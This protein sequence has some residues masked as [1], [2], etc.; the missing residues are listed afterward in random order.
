MG[1]LRHT[2]LTSTSSINSSATFGLQGVNRL[3]VGVTTAYRGAVRTVNDFQVNANSGT[4]HLDVG[5]AGGTAVFMSV[6]SWK[7]TE[8]PTSGTASYSVIV[9]WSG[10]ISG[11]RVDFFEFDNID[12]TAGLQ[13]I[14]NTTATAVTAGGSV[15]VTLLNA[16]GDIGVGIMGAADGTISANAS[17]VFAQA[18]TTITKWEHLTLGAQD[19]MGI[20]AY[21][22]SVLDD[23]ETYSFTIDTGIAAA[24]VDS[25]IVI[26]FSLTP[27]SGAVGRSGTGS[28]VATTALLSGIGTRGFNVSA[29]FTA[30]AATLSGT[31]KRGSVGSAIALLAGN[32]TMAGSGVAGKVGS[33]VLTANAAVIA[34]SGIRTVKN[35]TAALL[36]GN[37]TINGTGIREIVGSG[38]MNATTAIL[39]GT[40][41]VVGFVTGSGGLSSD[42]AVIA[43]SGARI[44]DFT[45]AL[46]A[47][48]ATLTGT[49]IRQVNSIT[50]A[51]S[52]GAATIS[53]NNAGFPVWRARDAVSASGAPYWRAQLK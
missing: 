46:Q 12:Q 15:S 17:T 42:A 32:A 41:S 34:G 10:V 52:A 29:S 50:A 27:S 18:D 14:S 7:D 33:G 35:A 19:I 53:G 49:G 3:L 28:L 36:A 38:A 45:A 11:A 5:A 26:A 37:A 43:G 2:F 24:V 25:V 21:E 51:L 16:S 30:T 39:S 6:R 31:G 23:S 40:G 47:Q 1:F 44:I 48:N 8:L 13:N 9:D 4:E 22:N 20:T